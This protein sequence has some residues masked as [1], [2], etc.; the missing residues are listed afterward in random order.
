MC[1]GGRTIP[2][3]KMATAEGQAAANAA[4]GEKNWLPIE[5]N[6]EVMST[7]SAKLGLPMD[8]WQFH[9]VLSDEE[10]ALQMVPQPVKAVLMLFPIK[11]ASEAHRRAEAERIATSGQAPVPPSL[12][13]TEQKIA[14]ACGT[15]GIIH[16]IANASMLCGGDIA[17]PEG[18][19][20]DR[21]IRQTAPMSPAQRAVELE[22]DTEAEAEHS[23]VVHQGQSDVVEDTWNHFVCFIEKGGRLWELDGRKATPIDHGPTTPETLLADAAKVMRQFMDRDPGELRFTL[24]ALG[25]ALPPDEEGEQ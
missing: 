21:F 4:A 5:S 10:W 16:A 20:F 11:D 13:F 7:Y 12:W 19:W 17:L 9:D 23:D 25:P 2:T 15:I 3:S 14:N 18:C 1:Q 8:V 6:P 24:V 22:A